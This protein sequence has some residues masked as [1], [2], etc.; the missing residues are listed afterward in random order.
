MALSWLPDGSLD[1]IR[2]ALD[3]VAPEL[4]D[5][6]IT[7]L[8]WIDQSNPTWWRR[9]ARLNDG[10][11][12]KFAW[13]KPAAERVWHEAEVLRVL[14]SL[15]PAMRTPRLIAS[16][17][18]P[19]LLVS[20]WVEGTPLTYDQLEAA[21]RRWTE[22][23]AK[24]MAL[25]LSELHRPQVLAEMEKAIGSLAMSEP[26]GTTEAIRRRL[27]PWLRAD[28]TP[29][30]VKWCDWVDRTLGTPQTPVFVHGDMHGH[31]QVW[32]PVQPVLRVVVDFEES[33]VSDAAYDFRYLPSQGPGIELLVATAASYAEISGD[34][35]DIARV[36]AWN[37]RTVLGDALWRS[38]AGV[39]MPDGGTPSDWVDSLQSRLSELGTTT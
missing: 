26:Q 12:A 6:N 39:P 16:S 21:N 4:S 36:M 9:S 19:V 15:V 38:E 34:A 29:L 2:W 10:F 31:N 11:V 30:I 8:P 20:K 3:R 35:I 28:Q 27:S 13:S 14:D 23:A 17:S 5:S 37:I 24:E 1:S 7:L 33:G 22:R 25:F 18:D 32:D